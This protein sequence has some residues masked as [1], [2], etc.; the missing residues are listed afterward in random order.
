MNNR[1][2]LIVV[3][4]HFIQIGF[5]YSQKRELIF[6]NY[7]IAK[8][9]SHNTVHCIIQDEKGFL[10]IGT[11]DGLNRFD[12]YSFTTFKKN[13]EDSFSISDNFVNSLLE[14][15]NQTLWLGTNNRGLNKFDKLTEQFKSF[16]T[17]NYQGKT[18]P[19]RMINAIV[20]DR[21]GHL[22]LGTFSGLFEF[23][24][25]RDTIIS[26]F[27]KTESNLGLTDEEIRCLY[28]DKDDILWIGTNSGGLNRFDIKNQ[29]FNSFLYDSKDTTSISNNSVSAILRDKSGNLWVG[30]SWGFN[31]MN[32][33]DNK[34]KHFYNDLKNPGTISANSISSIF[35]DH[36]NNLWIGTI[37]GLD[38]Y[39]KKRNTFNNWS[40]VKSKNPSFFDNQIFSLF[41]D[42]FGQM[43][44]GTATKG[45]IKFNNQLKKFNCFSLDG[46]NTDDFSSNNIIREIYQDD[47]LKLW[48]G[49]LN[50]GIYI[51]NQKNEQIISIKHNPLD[52][53]S[54]SDNRVNC[55]YKDSKANL[56]VG[57]WEGGLNLIKPTNEPYHFD[58]YFHNPTD[59]STISSNVIK[60]IIEDRWNRIWLGTENGL[61]LFDP[62]EKKAIH[63]S[64][65]KNKSNSLV[66]NSIQSGA[67]VF[68][69]QGNMWVG[70]WGGLSKVVFSD[71]TRMPEKFLNY[72]QNDSSAFSLNENRTIALHVSKTN[73]LYAGT[74]GG[75]LNKI[76]L[77]EQC[78][79]IDIKHFTEKEGLSN[80]VVY[81]ILEDG[82]GFLWLS[83]NN[84]LS[85]FNAQKEQFEIYDEND[86]LV[87]NQFYWGAACNLKTGELAFG[88]INGINTFFPQE[89]QEDKIAPEVVITDFRIFDQ[90]PEISI[91][92]KLTK[93]II[94]SDTIFLDY[95]DNVISFEFSALQ[96]ADQ[97][98]NKYAFQLEGFNEQW[99]YTDAKKRFAVFTNLEPKEYIFKVKGS[100][101]DGLWSEKVASIRIIVAPPYWKTWWFRILALLFISFSLF[102]FYRYRVASL[103]RQK[104]QL[105]KMVEEKTSEVVTQKDELQAFNEELTATNEELYNQREELETTLIR[106]KEAQH[107]LIQAEKMAS[108]GLL[109]AGIAHEIN[110]P[111]NFI[112]GGILA[113]ESYFKENIPDHKVKIEPLID[114][115]NQ[116]VKRASEIVT[117]LRHYS[118]KD[119]LLP[120][121]CDVHEILDNCLIMLQNQIKNK[122]T[123][124]KLYYHKPCIVFGSEG[125]L[126]Q[127]FLNII[128]NAEQAISNKGTIEIKTV[129]LKNSI[130]ITITD[131][132]EGIN[133]ENLQKIFDPFFTTKDPGKGTGLGM[134]ITYNII[135][136][137]QGTIEYKSTIGLGTTVIIT[138]PAILNSA[139]LNQTGI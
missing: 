121:E 46:K 100:N 43:W 67:L 31:L 125:K 4:I 64:H 92:S 135:K 133:P 44:A 61:D 113:I 21:N 35:E 27:H 56:W 114:A 71:K 108:L 62:I 70:T 83:T 136:E 122:V 74:F 68:D 14:D 72:Q 95:K 87:S 50:G 25:I 59:S 93:S 38:Q 129:G 86:G 9:L 22:W 82:D 107:Q 5:G 10:W 102:G 76:I 120:I 52:P 130:I 47:E 19:L 15:K 98:K 41:E 126:H 13:I 109:S 16:E 132:G 80:N 123:L 81:T 1:F 29:T 134:A 90:K 110:N 65:Q 111:L 119:D 124:N 88:S 104:K 18:L 115:V 106:L 36:L 42:K 117:S 11:E 138:I 69:K 6:E 3:F 54:L 101:A 53:Q 94:Y 118:R 79:I 32:E 84:G 24:P 139:H 116:G 30:T 45:M 26:Q 2:G 49:I 77:N 20:E 7:S 78:E 96:F 8:G 66:N 91:G 103:R 63:Y 60:E 127:A 75:G 112:H 57:T 128:S 85:K 55:I 105:E 131:S 37:N 89:I 51:Y 99:I 137:H 28:L 40:F 33:K 58:H 17:Y 12:G 34:F 48:M 73:I 23:D 97:S 39:D